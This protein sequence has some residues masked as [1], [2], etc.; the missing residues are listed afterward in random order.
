[1]RSARVNALSWPVP[2]EL[3]GSIFMLP[4]VNLHRSLPVM[5]SWIVVLILSTVLALT[6]FR[7]VV[8]FYLGFIL[9]PWF[10][11]LIK[12]FKFGRIAAFVIGYATLQCTVLGLEFTY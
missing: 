10:A 8:W 4:L 3:V 12:T 6:G 7:V 2:P 1:M 9:V 5:N 11:E